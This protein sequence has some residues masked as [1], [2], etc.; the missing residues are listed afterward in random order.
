MPHTF[1][2]P[3]R[4]SHQRS[5]KKWIAIKSNYIAWWCFMEIFARWD[6]CTFGDV[7]D[8]HPHHIS[9]T[10]SFSFH[11]ISECFYAIANTRFMKNFFFHSS[12]FFHSP[13]HPYLHT[14]ISHRFTFFS[15]CGACFTESSVNNVLTNDIISRAGL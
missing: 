12:L 5:S 6:G 14:F 11:S 8:I 13:N 2:P 10:V 4:T 15:L 9:L 1:N 7:K 3:D